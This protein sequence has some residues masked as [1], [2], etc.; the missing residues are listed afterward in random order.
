MD[1]DAAVDTIGKLPNGSE[2]LSVLTERVHKAN[3]EA[4]GL[5][6]RYKNLTEALKSLEFDPEKDLQEQFNAK[7][8]GTKPATE[9]DALSKK[10]EK[11]TSELTTWK[12]TAQQ[13]SEEAQI[14]KAVEAF[15]APLIDAFGAKNAEVIKELYTAKRSFSVRD[16]V[17][18]IV[19]DSEFVPLA[20]SKG[21]GAIDKIKTSYPHLAI[22]KQTPGSKDV[23]A[24][25]QPGTNS[26]TKT[27]DRASFD[28]MPMTERMAF[29][30]EGG[31]LE[32]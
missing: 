7:L 25:S 30:K 24:N 5:R 13:A 1:Y 10:V 20:V 2:L 19:I 31:Q 22:T 18:G 29:F 9:F 16:G 15:H 32:Q 11:L 17:P 6:D 28:A 8:S 12:Q 23:N 14:S 3:S 27:L 26:T 21:V 4:K